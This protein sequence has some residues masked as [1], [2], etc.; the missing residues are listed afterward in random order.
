MAAPGCVRD[1]A[2]RRLRRGGR[3]LDGQYGGQPFRTAGLTTKDQALTLL[4]DHVNSLRLL[5]ED[6]QHT[7]ASDG[8]MRIPGRVDLVQAIIAG[9]RISPQQRATH[10]TCPRAPASTTRASG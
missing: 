3:R 7:G 5:L 2:L 10:A 1:P 9:L 6:P 8:T 4:V